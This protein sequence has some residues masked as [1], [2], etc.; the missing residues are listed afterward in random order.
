M[1]TRSFGATDPSFAISFLLDADRVSWRLTATVARRPARPHGTGVPAWGR[2]ARRGQRPVAV[3]RPPPVPVLA[4]QGPV[5]RWTG[6]WLRS[7]ARRVGKACGSTCRA[8][9][10]PYH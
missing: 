10:S 8:R 1:L 4:G 6:G 3:R 7:E 5:P 2:S 9:G